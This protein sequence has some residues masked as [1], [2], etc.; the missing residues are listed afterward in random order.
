MAVDQLLSLKSP[1]S[2][3][4]SELAV[5]GVNFLPSRP[6]RPVWSTLALWSGERPESHFH[7]PGHCPFTVFDISLKSPSLSQRPVC[8]SSLPSWQTRFQSSPC[9]TQAAVPAHMEKALALMASCCTPHLPTVSIRASLPAWGPT[10]IWAAAGCLG[11]TALLQ[12]RDVWLLVATTV[13]AFSYASHQCIK[14]L[15]TVHPTAQAK[16]YTLR[17]LQT[18]L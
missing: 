12:M 4:C 16:T 10:H 17:F 7:M 15:I 18:L 14:S 9:E 8:D 3:N 1:F 13:L 6:S 11:P 5:P 2:L